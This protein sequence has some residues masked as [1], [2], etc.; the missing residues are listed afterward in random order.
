MELGR[1]TLAAQHVWRSLLYINPA[2]GRLAGLAPSEG[3]DLLA[4]CC[5]RSV[6]PHGG[7][8]GLE[9]DRSGAPGRAWS[10]VECPSADR[11]RIVHACCK[12]AAAAGR[13]TV[14]ASIALREWRSLDS[15]ESGP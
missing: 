9:V 11:H 1:E 14:C 8:F 13:A 2:S 7:A 3:S 15:A 12:G 4:P 5:G 6:L 10:V